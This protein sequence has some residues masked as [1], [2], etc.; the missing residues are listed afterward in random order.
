MGLILQKSEAGLGRDTI[1]V[2]SPLR[3]YAKFEVI[4][5]KRTKSNGARKSEVTKSN[6]SNA[7]VEIL[8]SINVRPK[9]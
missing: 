1:A 3:S 4:E 9:L 5:V 2:N 7:G 8:A 6:G